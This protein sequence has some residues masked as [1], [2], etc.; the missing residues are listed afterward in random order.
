[1]DRQPATGLNVSYQTQI[2]GSNIWRNGD[3]NVLSLAYATTEVG[4]IASIGVTSRMPLSGAWRIGPRLNFDRR[5]LVSDGSVEISALP[6]MLIDYQRGRRLLQ[7]ELG[8]QLGKR[9]SSAQTQQ[10]QKTT[11]YYASLAYRIGF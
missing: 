8:G 6:S 2:Y 4:K 11:R 7:F 10:T 5:Q 9:D 3:F 1:V